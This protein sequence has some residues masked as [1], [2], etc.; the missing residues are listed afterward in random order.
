MTYAY[1]GFWTEIRPVHDENTGR[2][3]YWHYKIF[4]LHTE[5]F[6]FEGFDVERA[7]ALATAQAHIEA[8]GRS[9]AKVQLKAA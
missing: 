7:S 2:I 4:S 3:A 5:E 1:R 9:A 8:L 6:L